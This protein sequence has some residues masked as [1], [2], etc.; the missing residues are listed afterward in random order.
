MG[1]SSKLIIIQEN[2]EPIV[3]ISN[4]GAENKFFFSENY[5][6]GN[7]D[8]ALDELIQSSK[9]YHKNS[10]SKNEKLTI[11]PY[12]YG[13]NVINFKTKIIHTMN[14]YDVVGHCPL[15]SFLV[16]GENKMKELIETNLAQIYLVK[17]NKKYSLKDFL[18][19]TDGEKG[20]N[21]LKTYEMNQKQ[22]I[23]ARL[24]SNGIISQ[25]ANCTFS[26]P[27]GYVLLPYNFDFQVKAYSDSFNNGN[28]HELFI[29]LYQEGLKF[30]NQDIKGWY[31]YL[32][33]H[34]NENNKNEIKKFLKTIYEKSKLEKL[35]ENKEILKIKQKL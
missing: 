21:L 26:R 16:M 14:S 24:N 23:Q 20:F 5:L 32:E 22:L 31:D 19:T 13:I 2:V 28:V 30:K 35:I 6:S 17:E 27:S 3:L 12:H 34:D 18:G 15:L 25:Y 33:K 29:N 11:S 1:G 8:K 4:T 10:Y 7:I 9:E